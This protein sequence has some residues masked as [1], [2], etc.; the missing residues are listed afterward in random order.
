MLLQGKKYGESWGGKVVGE[1]IIGCF[2]RCHQGPTA[3][4][5]GKFASL[6]RQW[7]YSPMT[8]HGSWGILHLILVIIKSSKKGP[9]Y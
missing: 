8:V 2:D 6:P 7:N 3:L 4:G 9:L 1:E 5:D